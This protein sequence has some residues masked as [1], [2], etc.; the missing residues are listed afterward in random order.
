MAV[1]AKKITDLETR[2]DAM[3]VIEGVYLKEK[4]WIDNP[5]KEIPENTINSD[6]FSWFITYVNDKPAGLIRLAYDPSLT[7]PPELKVTLKKDI[8]L[9]KMAAQCKIVEIGR[10][11]ILPEYRRNILIAL[12]LMK[13]AISEVVERDYTHF[14]TDVFENEPNSPFRFHTKILGFEVIGTHVHG[15]LNCS[16]TRIIL[17]LDILKAY[18]KLK[19][20]KNKFSKMLVS[21]IESIL[22]KKLAKKMAKKVKPSS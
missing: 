8:D 20:R 16:C 4:K 15:E 11:M 13:I 21:G 5:E 9:E 19:K 1:T 6:R 14:L 22:E 3:K 17:T 7:F 12:R 10:F 18:Q 2:E